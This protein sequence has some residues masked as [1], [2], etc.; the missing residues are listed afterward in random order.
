MR[1][2]RSSRKRRTRRRGGGGTSCEGAVGALG[3]AGFTQNARRLA[4]V[5]SRLRNINSR[6]G[7]VVAQSPPGFYGRTA[8]SAAVLSGN[9]PRVQHLVRSGANLEAR[10]ILGASPL[11]LARVSG[12]DDILANLR[13]GLAS[14]GIQEEHVFEGSPAGVWEPRIRRSTNR[15]DFVLSLAVLSSSVLAVGY[16]S[17]L[18]ILHDITNRHIVKRLRGHEGLVGALLILPKPDPEPMLLAS[19]SDDAT[20]RIW[21]TVTGEC[22]ATFNH[23]F[24]VTSLALLNDG[25]LASGSFDQTVR[26]WDLTSKTCI[27]TLS[28]KNEIYSLAALPD[29]GLAVGCSNGNIVLWSGDADPVRK[30]TLDNGTANAVYSLTLLSDFRLAAGTSSGQIKVWDIIKNICDTVLEGHKSGVWS[31]TPLPDGRLLSGGGDGTVKL[32]DRDGATATSV[33]T[34]E[35]DGTS[36]RALAVWRDGS[37]LVASGYYGGRVRFWN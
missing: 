3:R 37:D 36:V 12:R 19:A 10:N 11:T 22:T 24:Y 27:N 21:N 26:I 18:I 30:G 33:K 5:T 13:A 9:L 2:P 29:G 20:V 17:G 15:A 7:M 35:G 31:L 1:Q 34:L 4:S 28:L 23:T 6:V 25:R 32:W 16:S 14:K 8:L